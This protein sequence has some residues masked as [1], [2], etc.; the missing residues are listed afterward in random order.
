MR[1]QD[2]KT[3]EPRLVPMTPEVRVSFE[4]LSKVRMLSTNRIFLYEGKPILRIKRA[5]NTALRNA[6][7]E[8]FR[9]H[10]LRHCAATNL[11]RAGVDTVTAMKIVGHKSEKMHRRYNSVSEADLLQAASKIN[12]YLTPTD[13]PQSLTALSH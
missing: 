10:D 4:T 9:F 3:G 13:S 11:R 6:K 8:N 12:T 2:T 7:I 1:S 5:F